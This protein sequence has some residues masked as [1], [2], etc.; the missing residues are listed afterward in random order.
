[1]K[2]EDC[3]YY[4]EVVETY[5]FQTS[6][7]TFRDEYELIDEICFNKEKG[8]P[9]HHDEFDCENCSFFSKKE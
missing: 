4:Q 5:R 8:G 1:M 3:K 7:T 2:K 9:F 6:E